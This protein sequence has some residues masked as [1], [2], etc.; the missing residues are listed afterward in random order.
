M[1]LHNRGLTEENTQLGIIYPIGY[2]KILIGN[3]LWNWDWWFFLWL[4]AT[5]LVNFPNTQLG[6]LSPIVDL[7]FPIW[8]KMP[9]WGYC[10]LVLW[11]VVFSSSHITKEYLLLFPFVFHYLANWFRSSIN[12]VQSCEG[13]LEASIV[14]SRH[15]VCLQH[16]ELEHIYLFTQFATAFRKKVKLFAFK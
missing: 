16:R 6:I 11:C 14:I 1:F 10:L 7:R 9:N 2:F 13:G 5:R 15:L 3:I 4:C 12:L 8:G